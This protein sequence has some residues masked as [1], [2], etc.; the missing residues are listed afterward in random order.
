MDFKRRFF[1][2]F[3]SLYRSGGHLALARFDE[4]EARADKAIRAIWRGDAAGL[5][6]TNGRAR[7][8]VGKVLMLSTARPP[9]INVDAM[10]PLKRPASSWMVP[11][12][13]DVFAL[14]AHATV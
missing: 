13:F 2:H 9:P 4:A 8:D 14:A 10:R 7:L 5:V 12:H 11:E 3:R 6:M 1:V